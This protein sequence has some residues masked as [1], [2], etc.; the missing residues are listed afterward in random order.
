MPAAQP[1]QRSGPQQRPAQRSGPQQA[2]QRRSGSP[3]P[4]AARGAAGGTARVHSLRA[5]NLSATHI[6]PQ[7]QN[8]PS[9]LRQLRTEAPPRGA[10]LPAPANGGGE[11]AGPSASP[12]PPQRAPSNTPVPP[13]PAYHSAARARGGGAAGVGPRQPLR[14]RVPS[15]SAQ[16]LPRPAV[17]WSDRQPLPR[18]G[19]DTSAQRSMSPLPGM[20]GQR[21]PFRG[22]QIHWDPVGK[23]SIVGLFSVPEADVPLPRVTA[24]RRSRSA[25]VSAKGDARGGEAAEDGQSHEP[26]SRT[27]RPQ[28]ERAA[29]SCYD[30]NSARRLVPGFGMTDR[31][32][33]PV[34]HEA[35]SPGYWEPPVGAVSGHSAMFRNPSPHGAEQK[36]VQRKRRGDSSTMGRYSLS[37]RRRH[38][39]PSPRP[40]SG[41]RPP[42]QVPALSASPVAA[43]VNSYALH[44][45]VLAGLPDDVVALLQAGENPEAEC[46]GETPLQLASKKAADAERLDDPSL[47][48]RRQVL[49]ILTAWLAAARREASSRAV[50]GLPEEAWYGVAAALPT[51]ALHRLVLCCRSIH[52]LCAPELQQRGHAAPEGGELLTVPPAHELDASDGDRGDPEPPQ[53]AESAEG[54]AAGAAA[55]EDA[56]APGTDPDAA[57][58]GGEVT[59]AR[60]HLEAA[61]ETL[62]VVPQQAFRGLRG[63]E[64]GEGAVAVLRMLVVLCGTP[65]QLLG[66]EEALPA[67]NLL[68]SD[69]AALLG[70]LRVYAERPNKLS[71]VQATWLLSLASEHA[72]ALN[73]SMDD[74]SAEAVEAVLSFCLCLIRDFLEQDR[75]P[76][77]LPPLMVPPGYVWPADRR[78][79][80]L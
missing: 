59:G 36:P 17:A 37:P 51:A 72:A 38:P 3:R 32:A 43:R 55:E 27:P 11:R 64:M 80:T 49:A 47:H 25:G 57:G 78:R 23:G 10:P 60:V 66:P 50:A 20:Y 18:R 69:P 28:Q 65:P 29:F 4:F 16:P 5:G 19:M 6:S 52:N 56:A 62:L 74:E 71:A 8:P 76:P 67:A 1:T 75:C 58:A 21:P 77:D 42:G 34:R 44:S 13:L 68:L 53:V 73:F 79:V 41:G 39:S 24:R 54:E 26:R 15:S 2:P 48:D 31:R 61:K 12:Q 70:R 33:R 7:G 46:C 45:A 30:P 35:Y 14:R 22:G 40:F 63:A 9:T